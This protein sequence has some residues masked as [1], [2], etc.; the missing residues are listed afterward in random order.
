VG[1]RISATATSAGQQPAHGRKHRGVAPGGGALGSPP[2]PQRHPPRPAQF[3][4]HH[5]T[6]YAV[7]SPSALIRGIGM[8]N[9]HRLPACP[10]F[11]SS[12]ASDARLCVW[13]SA[14]IRHSVLF[15]MQL[16]ALS[17][18]S[19]SS[20]VADLEAIST[21]CLDP[22]RMRLYLHIKLSTHGVLWMSGD[23]RLIHTAFLSSLPEMG[24]N[25]V[26]WSILVRLL[27]QSSNYDAHVACHIRTAR[28]D[29]HCC[30]RPLIAQS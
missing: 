15:S 20:I 21:R 10:P 30:P 12:L 16:V 13:E 9:A 3:H 5:G 19:R 27:A 4:R 6:R 26:E 23:V 8:P 7:S 2:R 25:D 14:A 24:S 17:F 18:G 1:R 22:L 29:D 28:P 11:A